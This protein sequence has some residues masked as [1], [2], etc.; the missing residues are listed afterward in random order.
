[1]SGRTLENVEKVKKDGNFCGMS[2][3]SYE[4]VKAYIA[5]MKEHGEISRLTEEAAKLLIREQDDEVREEAISHV[6]KQLKRETP[7]GGTYGKLTAKD[8]KT[9]IKEIKRDTIYPKRY[10]YL[11]STYCSNTF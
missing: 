10:V 4:E 6:E 3:R 9:L 8:V 11:V 1:M 5:F 7:T 2:K